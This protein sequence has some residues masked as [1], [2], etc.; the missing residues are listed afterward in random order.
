LADPARATLSTRS[1][2]SLTAHRSLAV[3]ALVPVE[4][5]GS[6]DV[7]CFYS[8]PIRNPGY[9]H[10]LA[11]LYLDGKAEISAVAKSNGVS[12]VDLQEAVANL[13]PLDREALDHE[14]HRL[15]VADAREKGY[16]AEDPERETTWVL[17]QRAHAYYDRQSN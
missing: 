10:E 9:V 15:Y 4:I 11:A 7:A 3:L 6:W 8:Q 5:V 12:D 17:G 14:I 16:A 1:S 13:R 2:G